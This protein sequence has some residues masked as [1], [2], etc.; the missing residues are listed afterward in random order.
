MAQSI[1]LHKRRLLVSVLLTALAFHQPE[2]LSSGGLDRRHLAGVV[3]LVA[4]AGTP[5]TYSAGT[6]QEPRPGVFALSR[7]ADR[8][9]WFPWRFSFFMQGE[10]RPLVQMLRCAVRRWPVP[11]GIE[12]A[13]AVVACESSF[14]PFAVNPKS[15]TAGLFQQHPAY[16]HKR[17]LRWGKSLN[18]PPFPTNP[19]SNII[20]SIRIV[21]AYGWSAWSCA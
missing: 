8:P 15:K 1:R 17:W 10:T 9:C 13:M 11:G 2:T 3:P 7:Q 16:W 14:N 21:N 20:V 18:T 6:V 19:W 4:S 12:K 5:S